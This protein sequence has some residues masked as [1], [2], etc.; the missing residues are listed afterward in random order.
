MSDFLSRVAARA[1]GEAPVAQP[2]LPALFER[3]GFAAEPG[4]EVVEEEI[5]APAAS[6][7]GR[8]LRTGPEPL[9]SGDRTAAPAAETRSRRSAQSTASPSPTSPRDSGE[10]SKR[11]DALSLER[12]GAAGQSAAA[13]SPARV[14]AVSA[15]PGPE[16]VRT[17]A[18]SVAVAVPA[19]RAAPLAVPAPAVAHAAANVPHDEPP[20][21]VHIGRLE[22]RANLQEAPRTERRREEREPEGLALSDYLRGR[23]R[24]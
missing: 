14:P 17:T 22:V 24:A 4:L 15:S 18:T 9:P 6:S 12:S 1:V 3:A 11:N 8:E 16:P 7:A 2:R 21:R 13:A 19:R 20:V 10:P 23:K 5:V